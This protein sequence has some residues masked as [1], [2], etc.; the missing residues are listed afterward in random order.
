MNPIVMKVH[1]HIKSTRVTIPKEIILDRG[2]KD[3]IY[4]TFYFNSEGVLCLEPTHL[5]LDRALNDL[6]KDGQLQTT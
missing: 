6:A 4:F 1:K 2:W 5:A 3:E